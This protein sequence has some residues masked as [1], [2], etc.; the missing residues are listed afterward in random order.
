MKK[1]TEET[2]VQII[3]EEWSKKYAALKEEHETAIKTP[4]ISSGLKITRK[5]TGILYTVDSVGQKSVV[6]K[7][8]HGMQHTVSSE[9][10]EKEFELE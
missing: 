3:R 6:I 5:K 9:V 4:L 8:P 2:V 7:D 1:L 10:L